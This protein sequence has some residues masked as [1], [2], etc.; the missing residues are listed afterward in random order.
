MDEKALQ[1]KGVATHWVKDQ[2]LSLDYRSLGS[3]SEN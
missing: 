1:W 3:I 2:A